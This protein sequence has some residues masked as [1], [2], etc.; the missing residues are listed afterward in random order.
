MVGAELGF[1]KRQRLLAELEGVG[2]PAEVAVAVGQVRHAR[3]RVGVVG[4]E[5]LGVERAGLLNCS[6]AMLASPR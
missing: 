6:A 1:L 4:A 2:V 3:E 5:V